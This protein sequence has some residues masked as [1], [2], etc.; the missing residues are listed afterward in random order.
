MA[1]TEKKLRITQKKSAIGYKYD[2]GRTLKALGLGK[3]GR[4]VEQPD[5]PAIRGMVF[6]IKHLVDVE[7]IQ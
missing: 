3:I 5:N 7:E 4:T 6:K 1:D 2:Q